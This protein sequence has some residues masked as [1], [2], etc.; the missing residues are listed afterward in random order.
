MKTN[1]MMIGLIIWTFLTAINYFTCKN[2][3]L[4]MVFACYAVA[5]IFLFVIGNK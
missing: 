2:V 5:N 3:L 4:G 1:F